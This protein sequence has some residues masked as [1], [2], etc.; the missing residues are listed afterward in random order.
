[1]AVRHVSG[2]VFKNHFIRDY[3]AF[4]ELPMAIF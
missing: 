1:M 4:F 3:S 2:T